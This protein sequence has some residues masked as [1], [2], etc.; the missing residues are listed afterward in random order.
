LVAL[1]VHVW[2]LRRFTYGGCASALRI[3]ITIRQVHVLDA[4][5]AKG[6]GD[7][8]QRDVLDL[9]QRAMPRITLNLVGCASIEISPA[10]L[11]LTR[12]A[13]RSNQR[14]RP[15]RRGRAAL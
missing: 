10:A 7:A 12:A 1:L 4:S 13:R 8:R 14:C 2:G 6:A 15:C 5:N 11:G 3:R 9:R